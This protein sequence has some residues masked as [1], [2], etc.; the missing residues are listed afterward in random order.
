[1]YQS[2]FTVSARVVALAASVVLP[3]ATIAQT[4]VALGKSAFSSLVYH[5][6]YSTPD[7]AVDG[8][9]QGNYYAAPGIFHSA[10]PTNEWWYVDLGASYDISSIVFYNRTDCCTS[11]IIGST[12]GIFA[13]TPYTMGGVAPVQSFVFT[14]DAAM[15]TFTPVAG[16][17][18]GRYVGIFSP[19]DYLQIAEL[20]VF[21]GSAAPSA[22]PE[23]GTW[24]LLGTGLMTLA[25]LARRRRTAT[26]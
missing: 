9:T 3:A 4:N 25:G 23:P 18:T 24:A 22:V 7:K 26:A 16:T 1:M 15:Q 12:L 5:A 2:R 10:G 11:R 8:N 20:Q 17:R 13:A 14:M 6:G 19:N 21:A